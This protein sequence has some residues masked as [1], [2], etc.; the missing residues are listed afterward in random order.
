[1]LTTA[2]NGVLVDVAFP[3]LRSFSLTMRI[4]VEAIIILGFA[5]LVGLCAQIAI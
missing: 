5:I 2:S 4:T 3:S 1:M